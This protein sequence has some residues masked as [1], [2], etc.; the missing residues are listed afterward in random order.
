MERVARRAEA[1]GHAVPEAEIR[2]RYE[3]LWTQVAAMVP[4]ADSAE[5]YDNAGDRPRSAASFVAGE[6]V[7]VARWPGWAPGPLLRLAS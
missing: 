7:G 5:F 1:G 2:A 4:L 3:R 6:L